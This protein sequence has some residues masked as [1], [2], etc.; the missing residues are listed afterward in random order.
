MTVLSYTMQRISFNSETC[1]NTYPI[2]EVEN[3]LHL[4]KTIALNSQVLRN[5]YSLLHVHEAANVSCDIYFLVVNQKRL[6]DIPVSI[7]ATLFVW[8][9]L[10]HYNIMVVIIQC[11]E[12]PQYKCLLSSH[13][14]ESK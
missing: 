13:L 9:T 12:S 11:V 7:L 6:Q 3:L 4:R 1:E 5:S 10:V 8:S 2:M 14:P